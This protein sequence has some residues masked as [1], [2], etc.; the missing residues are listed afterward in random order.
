MSSTFDTVSMSRGNATYDCA[1]HAAIDS[2]NQQ[3]IKLGPSSYRSTIIKLSINHYS[4]RLCRLVWQCRKDTRA[5][6]PS[7]SPHNPTSTRPLRV[8]HLWRGKWTALS[9]PLSSAALSSS[10]DLFN[11][12]RFAQFTDTNVKWLRGGLVFKVH[13]LVCHS[14]LAGE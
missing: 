12:R 9:G 14:T 5:S 1:D 10:D 2:S 11:A 7:T 8:G 6:H 4:V 3:H 13:R